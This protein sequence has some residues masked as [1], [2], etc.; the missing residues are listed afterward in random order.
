MVGDMPHF[1]PPLTRSRTRVVR[2][3]ADI[4]FGHHIS[5]VIKGSETGGAIVVGA[6]DRLVVTIAEDHLI[7]YA[8]DDIEL[9]IVVRQLDDVVEVE[10]QC[11]VAVATGKVDGFDVVNRVDHVFEVTLAENDRRIC[12][13]VGLRC[14]VATTAIDAGTGNVV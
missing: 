1:I 11:Y 9:V 3:V 14:I 7:A 2:I 10:T 4:D 5:T 8:R 6:F 12:C 13:G